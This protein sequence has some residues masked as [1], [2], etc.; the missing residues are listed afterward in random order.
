[1]L[2]SHTER[3]LAARYIWATFCLFVFFLKKNN[4]FES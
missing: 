1:M 2:A 4:F 3:A